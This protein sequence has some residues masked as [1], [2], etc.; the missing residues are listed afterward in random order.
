MEVGDLPYQREPQSCATV[1]PAARLVHPEE[2]LEDTALIHLRDAAAGVGDAEQELFQLL[3]YRNLH[4]A[5][6]PVVLDSILRQIED[7][8]VDQCI[9]A[10]HNSVTL[11]LQRNAVFL[12]QRGEVREDLLDHGGE[13]D[14]LVPRHLPQIAHF[15]QRSG[16][17]GQPLRLLPL[18]GKKLHRLWPHIGM[19]RGK[20]LQLRLHQRQ[21]RAQLVGSVAGELPLGGKSVVQPLQHLVE[22]AA[23][24]PEL[25]NSVLIDP[26][27]G[28]IVQLH[29]LHLRGK[30]AQG[31]ESASADEI[32][33]DAAE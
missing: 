13:L 26:H 6:R 33:E 20:Q 22:R 16:H 14:L 5:A 30:A 24:L 12:R 9:A 11:R 18:K 23:Q 17:L 15:Q 2:G 3:S 32:G 4:R 31:L 21:R 29:L 28:K 8:P 19:L 27:I 10:S 1:F 7:Q 25:R